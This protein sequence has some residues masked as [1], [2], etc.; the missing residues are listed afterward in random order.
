MGSLSSFSHVEEEEDDED[1]ESETE[2]CIPW[3][4]SRFY[5]FWNLM[6]QTVSKKR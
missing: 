4:E 6:G 5:F 2:K 1:E 3:E